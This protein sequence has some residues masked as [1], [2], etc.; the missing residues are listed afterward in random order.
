MDKLIN[1]LHKMYY[2]DKVTLDVFIAIE[3]ILHKIEDDVGELEDQRLLS[4]ATFYIE[5]LEKE[6]G[7]QSIGTLQERRNNIYARLLSE[8]KASLE[9]MRRICQVYT[10][11]YIVDY[12]YD[13][14][15]VTL[16]LSKAVIDKVGQKIYNEL[17]AY[18]PAH[19]YIGVKMYQRTHG[20]IKRMGYTYGF[21]KRFTHE[22]IR[23]KFRLE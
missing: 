17:R 7:L 23:D 6:L 5:L 10:D 22:E 16:T 12:D 14:A 20:E 15:T 19:I 4:S 3:K 2:K 11:E 1:K 9:G 8:E 13:K 21:L 18:I